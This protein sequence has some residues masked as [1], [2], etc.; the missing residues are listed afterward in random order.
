M[1]SRRLSTL[2]TRTVRTTAI[3][4]TRPF[5]ISLARRA[6]AAAKDSHGEHHDDH[7]H[8]S[9]FD[10]PG[11]WLWGVRPGEKREKEGWEGMFV[12]MC[13]AY[14]AAFIAIG[15]KEDTS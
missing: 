11:G 5:S 13:V 14:V 12:L 4:T 6:A 2:A 10:P 15:M 8:E 9:H 7:G 1:L 3:S